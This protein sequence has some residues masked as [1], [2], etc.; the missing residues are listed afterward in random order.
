MIRPKE[1]NVKNQKIVFVNQD[2]GY[3][4]IDIVNAF[5]RAGYDCVLI[6]GRLVE[7]NTSLHEDVR[8]D[9]IIRY[10]RKNPFKRIFTWSYAFIQ[11]LLRVLISYRHDRLFIVS[12][13]PF[14]PLLPV[15][16]NNSFS[17]LIFDI[18]PDA[19]VHNR[20]IKQNSLT[21]RLWENANSKVYR[22]AE[23]VY[24]LSQA[25]KKVLTK[26]TR[27]NNIEVVPLWTDSTFLQ[28][29]DLSE[30]HFIRK[31][32]LQGRFVILYSGNIGYTHRID[33]LIDVAC[34][35]R[36]PNI[37]FLIIGSGDQ[38]NTIT[39]KIE[40]N[41]LQNCM[42][43]PWQP[44]EELPFSLAAANLAVVSIGGE[45]S[46]LSVPSKT[47]NLMSV[48]APLL[49]LAPEDSEL[50]RLVRLHNN[51]ASFS[52]DS[53]EE[54]VDFIHRVASNEGYRKQLAANSL[55]ASKNYTQENAHLFL[56]L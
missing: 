34:K 14:A 31:H 15:L 19:L 21:A 16:V 44:V 36:D 51:G 6:T 11:I 46:K 12:N 45:T 54:I 10:S 43:L 37:I 30:N 13:P 2:S 41:Q 26:Y 18:Y 48:G 7:R 55:E 52:H 32:D 50:S 24:V 56:P 49:C 22:R 5:A 28:P 47:F 53:I 23:V 27:P 20:I 33:V 9:R 39:R 40:E 42:L 29:V 25:M 3:L 35:V 4:M 8:L 1:Q 38:K 17:L